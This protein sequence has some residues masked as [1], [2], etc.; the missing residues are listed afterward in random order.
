M[1]ILALTGVYT[2]ATVVFGPR[3]SN[4]TNRGII[5][6]GPFRWTKHPA[7]I[8]KNLSWWLI[9]VPFVSQQGAGAAALNCLALLGVN[10]IYWIRA[11]TEERHLMQDPVYQEYAAWV[12]ANGWWA[13][14]RRVWNGARAQRA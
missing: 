8:S 10:A 14:C 6:S 2:W 1:A 12:A 11:K 13:K 9:A 5:T 7:Y 4:L 3:F